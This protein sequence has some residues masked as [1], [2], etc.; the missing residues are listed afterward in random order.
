MY[1]DLLLI[2]LVLFS[3][4]AVFLLI[5]SEEINKNSL[6][7]QIYQTLKGVKLLVLVW[8]AQVLQKRVNYLL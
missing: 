4:T 1:F 2:F 3:K 8:L 5:P 6:K 7:P